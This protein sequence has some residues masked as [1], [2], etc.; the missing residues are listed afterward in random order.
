[1]TYRIYTKPTTVHSDNGTNF[2]GAENELNSF[3][4][5][6]PKSG[7]FQQFLKVKNIDWRFQ[8]PR[9]PHFGGAHESFVRSTKRALYRV[10]EIEKAGLRYLTDA[11]Y[12]IG[13]GRW[14][15]ECPSSNLHQYGP[16][17]FSALNSK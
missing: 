15:A 7:A 9:A 11:S 14:N 2:V 5:E 1:M 12:S 4:Q 17:R 10:L 3:V 8:P 6:L 16:I 13:G